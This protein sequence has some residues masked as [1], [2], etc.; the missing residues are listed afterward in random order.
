MEKV[1]EDEEESTEEGDSRGA[2]SQ[3]D[4]GKALRWE[5]AGS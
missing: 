1:E 2:S 5:V 3:L 4:R